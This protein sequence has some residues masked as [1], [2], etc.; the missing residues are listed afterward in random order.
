[1][2]RW[3]PWILG[4]MLAALPVATAANYVLVGNALRDGK[5]ARATQCHTF[6]ISQKL[7][8]AA[9]HYKLITRHDLAVYLASRPRGC[10]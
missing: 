10:P 5:Q 4:L 9:A 7:Y 2:R 3:V 6:P 1:M 8:R